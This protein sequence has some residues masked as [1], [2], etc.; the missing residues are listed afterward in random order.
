M[1]NVLEANALAVTYGNANI[2]E[3]LHLQI[4]KGK[5]TVLV[6]ANGCG[7]STL[8]RTFARLIKPKDGH[9][10]IRR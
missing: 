9:V 3:D 8:L 7:K 6:G 2:L 4:P 1:N 5:I 10:L